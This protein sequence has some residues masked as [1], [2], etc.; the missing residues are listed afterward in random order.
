MDKKK[1][2]FWLS[3]AAIA[4]AVLFVLGYLFISFFDEAAPG[5]QTEQITHID[6]P[7][8]ADGTVT[9]SNPQGEQLYQGTIEIA[10]TDQQREQGLMYRDSL[11]ADQGMLFVF[12]AEAPQAFW[13]KNTRMALDIL[14]IG[15]NG[16]IVSIA[17][18]AR[19]YDET[20]LPSQAPAQ[21][22]LEI[23]GGMCAARGI[24]A[25]DSVSWTQD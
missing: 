2:Q 7:F 14:Y 24:Q 15:A 18:N 25:G 11:G 8:R 16:T 12:P 10:S 22:V 3:A 13:M 4:L 21:Y 17:E 9:I 5:F 6:I 20:S 1:K 23:P 19:P